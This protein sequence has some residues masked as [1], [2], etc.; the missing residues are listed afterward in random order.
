MS[1]G[2]ASGMDWRPVGN[3]LEE[4]RS[5]LLV[6]AQQMRSHSGSQDRQ[7]RERMARR[8]DSRHG[9][10]QARFIP[11]APIRELRDVT[12]YR[13]TLVQERAESR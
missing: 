3:V 1:A 10:L 12:R 9:L 6:N 8:C 5:V 11:P 2:A 7:E 4:G 13:K